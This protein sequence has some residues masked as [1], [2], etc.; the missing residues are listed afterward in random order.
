MC[1]TSK[2]Q[3]HCQLVGIWLLCVCFFSSSLFPI[4]DESFNFICTESVYRLCLIANFAQLQFDSC[5]RNNNFKITAPQ[6]IFQAQKNCVFLFILTSIS[7][8]SQ[9]QPKKRA[10]YAWQSNSLMRLGERHDAYIHTESSDLCHWNLLFSRSRPLRCKPNKQGT[11]WRSDYEAI[12]RFFSHRGHKQLMPVQVKM[13]IA[14][15]LRVQ[16][17]FRAICNLKM[18][19]VCTVHGILNL[20]HL[21]WV[22]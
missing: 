2:F 19:N 22:I 18:W 16:H 4:M 6:M 12:I 15:S 8:L 17:E 7:E 14:F 1:R 5:A 13:F 10:C 9:T 3:I 20:L 21:F 11:K